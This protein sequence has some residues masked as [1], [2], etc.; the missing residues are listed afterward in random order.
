MRTKH[1][2]RTLKVTALVLIASVAAAV[3]VTTAAHAQTTFRN[4][5]GQ[6]IG[7]AATNGN[8]TTYRDDRGR[9][10]GTATVDSAGTTTFRDSS[11]RTVGTA[12]AP[13]RW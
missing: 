8:Q 2:T 6:T 13:R 1:D 9:T 11:G 3:L 10:T 4:D 7:T 5:R 12:A